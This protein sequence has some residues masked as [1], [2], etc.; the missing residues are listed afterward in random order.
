MSPSQLRLEYSPKKWNS[1]R[2]CGTH[3]AKKSFSLIPEMQATMLS[4]SIMLP[5]HT[6]IGF[7]NLRSAIWVQGRRK[8]IIPNTH[9]MGI[10][11]HKEH[12]IINNQRSKRKQLIVKWFRFCLWSCVPVR[13]KELWRWFQSSCARSTCWECDWRCESQTQHKSPRLTGRTPEASLQHAPAS[14]GVYYDPRSEECGTAQLLQG[15]AKTEK[16]LNLF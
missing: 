10:H 14:R 5:N 6:C 13:W 2:K 9:W 1:N 7:K 16:M 8:P 15:E 3:R 12:R 11:R 4:I